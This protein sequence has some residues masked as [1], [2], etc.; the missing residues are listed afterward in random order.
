MNR[1]N[2]ELNPDIPPPA[3]TSNAPRPRRRWAFQLAALGLTLVSAFTGTVLA[4]WLKSPAPPEQA[5]PSVP[6]SK[7]I[8]ARLFPNWGKPDFVVVLSAQQHGYMLPCGCS[9][10]QVGGLER[11]YNFIQLLK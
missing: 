4:H 1:P 11:R 3:S 9:E 10:P 6:E 7:G 5:K 8:P 2:D